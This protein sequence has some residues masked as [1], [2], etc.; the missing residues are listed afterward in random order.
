MDILILILAGFATTLTAGILVYHYPNN[1]QTIITIG[2]VILLIISTLFVLKNFTF[3]ISS[4]GI[5]FENNNKTEELQTYNTDDSGTN[6]Q[7]SMVVDGKKPTNKITKDNNSMT[8]AKYGSQIHPQFK[9]STQSKKI[10]NEVEHQGFLRI[11]VICNSQPI[12]FIGSYVSCAQNKQP[13]LY[14]SKVSY[15]E[16]GIQDDC[17]IAFINCKINN[18][19]WLLDRYTPE[20]KMPNCNI[21]INGK[22]ILD[23]YIVKTEN[24]ESANFTVK[25]KRI[26]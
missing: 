22:I 13:E 4:S 14:N 16:I 6:K 20:L 8:G 18:E 15:V 1:K 3:S 11:R 2:I 5:V 9:P 19:R 26:K 12:T 21:E 25:L 17:E 23:N 10:D 24:G 7:N